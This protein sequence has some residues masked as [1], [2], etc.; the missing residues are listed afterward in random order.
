MNMRRF[1][2]TSFVGAVL[3][4]LAPAASPHSN[5]LTL[6]GGAVHADR[7]PQSAQ[8]V[9]NINPAH[10]P[11]IAGARPVED[12]VQAAFDTW[13]SAPN[14]A[15]NVTRGNDSAVTTFGMD[16]TNLI[17]F[18]CHGDFDS[19]P[20]TLAVTMTT[21][22]TEAGVPDGN[23]GTT[24]FAGQILDADII[25][26]SAH[27][28]TVDGSAGGQ[29]LQ[30]VATHEIG[31]FFGLAH[32]AVVRAVMYPFAPPMQTR[33][34]YD[35]VAAI[36]VNYGK[37]APD[38]P[39]VSIAGTVRFG[40]AGVFGAHVF[41][42]STTSAEPFAAFNIRK[43]PIG[44]MTLPDGSYVISGV[45]ADSYTVTAEPLDSPVVDSN[46]AGYAAAYGRSAMQTGFTT[47]W[48]YARKK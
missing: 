38:I 41:A 28:F 18:V 45:P 5:N 47:R 1:A 35:D 33:L 44:A 29:D 8:L 30:T 6:I 25:F 46:L 3:L 21:V 11:N 39:T 7:W 40:G 22:A 27:D 26:N 17:C 32:S 42:D 15:L 34:S 20:E 12:V 23:G 10:G 19:E 2:I 48:H 37:A 4:V 13:T 9:W 43:S 24:Q 16:G 31:H 36:S 14:A